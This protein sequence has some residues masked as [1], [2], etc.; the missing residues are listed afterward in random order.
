MPGNNMKKEMKTELK[1]EYLIKF[2]IIQKLLNEFDPCDFF[3]LDGGWDNEYDCL[4]PKILSMKL[5]NKNDEEIRN[6]ILNELEN[7]FGVPDIESMKENMRKLFFEDLDNFIK[8][9]NVIN[10]MQ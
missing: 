7:H 9:L 3:L 1:K 4:T 10:E 2:N 5:N 8:K 6:M